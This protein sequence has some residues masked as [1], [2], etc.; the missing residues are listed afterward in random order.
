MTP[1]LRTYMTGRMLLPLRKNREVTRKAKFYCGKDDQF[2]FGNVEF[3]TTVGCDSMEV[4][5]MKLGN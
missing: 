1:R 5:L 2:Y 3:E 4:E